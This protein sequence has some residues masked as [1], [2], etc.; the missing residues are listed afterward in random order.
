[1]RSGIEKAVGY[2]ARSALFQETEKYSIEHYLKGT[3]N[4]DFS[5]ADAF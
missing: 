2:T 4:P 3:F 1:M 5:F